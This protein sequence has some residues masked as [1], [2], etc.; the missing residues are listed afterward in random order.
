MSGIKFF[1]LVILVIYLVIFGSH[2]Y[3]QSDTVKTGKV[4]IDWELGPPGA[5]V[6]FSFPIN[7]FNSFGVGFNSLYITYIFFP[8]DNNG[9]DSWPWMNFDLIN[10]KIF[11]RML[12][13]KFITFEYS[14]KYSYSHFGGVPNGLKN[15]QMYGVQ[16]AP[17]IG[18]GKAKWKPAI[19]VTRSVE[20][21]T[22]Y[23]YI[24]PL[25]FNFNF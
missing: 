3:G 24:M 18:A 6:N 21:P 17:I 22:I 4:K 5:G 1:L 25:V 15:I 13:S 19:A 9:E 7:N 2:T 20:N 8:P 14:I 11:Y 16:V 23:F 10:S 12:I